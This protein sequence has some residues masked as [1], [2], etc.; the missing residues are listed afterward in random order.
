[1]LIYSA[2]EVF[3][4]TRDRS[5]TDYTIEIKT[6]RR[7]GRQT[8]DNFQEEKEVIEVKKRQAFLD[9]LLNHHLTDGSL[10][11][12]DIRE[13]GDTFMF[14]GHDTTSMKISWSL[15]LL[16]LHPHIQEKLYQALEE[17][18]AKNINKSITSEELKR[19]KYLEC[20]VKRRVSYRNTHALSSSVSVSGFCHIEKEF[21]RFESGYGTHFESDYILPANS[22]L[23]VNIYGIYH[24]PTVFENPEVFDPDRFLPE[25]CQNHHPFA[26][27][28]FYAGPRDCI[29]IIY[30]NNS[31]LQPIYV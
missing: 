19:M 17:I 3:N 12:E 24:N 7:T 2:T 25:N 8:I 28:P 14:E 1:M 27:I 22:S 13:E 5:D 18:F 30:I 31:I 26:F 4:N 29:A 16:E 21:F 20:V 10:D 6:N 9:L 15:Y 11:E 23:T